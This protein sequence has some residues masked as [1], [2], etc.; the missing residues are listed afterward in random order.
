MTF[1]RIGFRDNQE[2]NGM[3]RSYNTGLLIAFV[4]VVVLF[5]LFV[6]GALSGSFMGG[7]TRGGG[8]MM[9]GDFGGYRWMLVPTLITF[10]AGVLLGWML[11]ARKR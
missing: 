11:F 10:A 1:T 9:G 3:S 8:G 4:V 2:V 7:W 5:L 6:G